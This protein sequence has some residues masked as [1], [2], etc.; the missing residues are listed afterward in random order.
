MGDISK[1]FS[2]KE[3]F[4]ANDKGKTF[5]AKQPTQALLDTLEAIRAEAGK[6]V[7][8][9]SGIRS[10]EYNARLKG[11]SPNSGHLTGE[12]ADIYVNGMSN[13]QLGAVIR[14]LHKSGKLPHLAYTY[15]IKDSNRAVHVG[16]DKKKRASIW[17]AG[18]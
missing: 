3:F 8:I 12:A 1:N 13:R 17:G 14:Q 7:F 10:V 9:N 11:S 18:Y 16:V 2:L 4:S 15:L 6:E 5:K